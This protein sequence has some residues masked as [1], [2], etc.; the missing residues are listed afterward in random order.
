MSTIPSFS[1]P[2]TTT[3]PTTTTTEATPTTTEATPPV[4]SRSNTTYSYVQAIKSPSEMGMSDAGNLKTLEKDINGLIAY[5]KLLVDGPSAASRTSGPLGSQFF[6]PTNAKCN[7]NGVSV[8]R[9]IYVDNIPKGGI[10]A[11]PGANLP[12]FRGL[13]PGM[14]TGLDAIDPEK[15]SE[16]IMNSDSP[17][18]IEVT[19]NVVDSSYNTI[20]ETNYLTIT[21][22]TNIDP[23]SYTNFVNPITKVTCNGKQG[24]TNRSELL[25][26]EIKHDYVSQAFLTSVGVFSIFILH[27]LVKNRFK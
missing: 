4:A 18:C 16:S 20:S 2:I 24:F 26:E 6:V 23:C 3:T 17:D 14:M 5:V 9:S 13:I 21:D 10:G 25:F 15:I 22:A 7:V 12:E 8:P 19:L 1:N 11:A 27:L